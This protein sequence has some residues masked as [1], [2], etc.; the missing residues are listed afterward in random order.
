MGAMQNDV[1]SERATELKR[2]LADLLADAPPSEGSAVGA[3]SSKI[4][5]PA[6]GEITN[7][8]SA[9]DVGLAWAA[10]VI[11]RWDGRYT[12]GSIGASLFAAFWWRWCRRIAAARF[13]A[14]L[15]EQMAGA[16]N[17][18]AHDLLL[19]PG[20]PWFER[21]T[22]DEARAAMTEALHWLAEK[23][24]TDRRRWTW[25]RLHPV[26]LTH[27]LSA[28]RP[29]F[30]EFFDL[31]PRPCPGGSGVLNQNGYLVRDRLA[32][33]SGPHY[34]F[35]ADLAEPT[36]A[37]GVN[38]AGNAGNPASPHYGD[39]LED[40]LAGRY[41][42]LWMDRADVEANAEATLRLEPEE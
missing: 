2:A 8:G 12:L 36:R 15:V 22:R 25:G 3:Q 34:R 21:P 27:A 14:H 7:A 16:A 37:R 6:S 28:G 30:A 31:G 42:P 35:L 5:A 26:T 18:I 23:L 40:W 33:T 17:A 9:E 19:E 24:G 41:H 1:Y 13:P 10:R 11:H 39:Q 38:T 29:V 4:P 20:L 32:T